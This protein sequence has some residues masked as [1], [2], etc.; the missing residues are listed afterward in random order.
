MKIAIIGK[1]V[2]TAVSYYRVTPLIDLCRQNDWQMAMFQPRDL[3]E[4]VLSY[5]DIVFM[6]RPISD[7]ET[8]LL[9]RAKRL[10]VK[11]WI[12]IDDLLWQIP[13]TNPALLHHGPEERDNL[14][15]NFL[16]CDI[17]TC[18]TQYLAERIEQEFARAA[19]VVPNAWHERTGEAKTYNIQPDKMRVLYRGSNTHDGDLFSHRSAFREYKNI[20]FNFMGA[21]P[22]Y[23]TREYGG[24]LKTLHYEKWTNSF[25]QY[26]ERLRAINPTF[27][28]V[29]LENNAFNKAKSN[30]SAIEATMYAG[31]VC[32]Y[33]S[34]LPEFSKMPGIPYDDVAHLHKVLAE[35][36]GQSAARFHH[37]H[38]RATDYVC[39]T[40]KLSDVNHARA[41]VV[42]HLCGTQR[43]AQS[44]KGK[45]ILRG[46][47]DSD[48]LAYAQ[49]GGEGGHN[50]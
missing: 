27:M 38:S 35:L 9:W 13:F 39:S 44:F 48:G 2:E 3:T 17:I 18:S 47:Y 37:V 45:Y 19:I 7:A 41:L 5:F 1:K 33:P 49:D 20:E 24:H 31:A 26:L 23:F 46:I 42:E 30:I 14:L 12:D 29:P 21:L 6:H 36:D 15:T 25:Q 32:I 16:N 50:L 40:L 22:W 8:A 11:T 4:D 43:T 34:Y 10:G 28:I